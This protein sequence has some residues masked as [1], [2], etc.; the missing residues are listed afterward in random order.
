MDDFTARILL[1]LVEGYQ[2]RAGLKEHT[3]ALSEYEI[4][5]RAGVASY[6]YTEFSTTA[7]RERV[8]AALA[9]LH[10][11][12]WIA[13]WPRAGRYDAFVPTPLGLRRAASLKTAGNGT[14]AREQLPGASPTPTPAGA[15]APPG[16]DAAR[17]APPELEAALAHLARQLDEVLA[18]LRAIDSKLEQGR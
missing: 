8:R 14:A 15:P 2:A 9:A 18:L 11:G 7:E 6:S 4:A 17:G 12:G 3:R 10:R 13:R 16:R 1:A 5:R